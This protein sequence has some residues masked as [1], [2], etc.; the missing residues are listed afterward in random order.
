MLVELGGEIRAEGHDEEGDDDDDEDGGRS[1]LVKEGEFHAV[2]L[3]LRL[4]QLALLSLDLAFLP[5]Y[6]G[7]GNVTPSGWDICPPNREPSRPPGVGRLRRYLLLFVLQEFNSHGQ[8]PRLKNCLR[9]RLRI[10]LRFPIQGGWP[11][12]NGKKI[13]CCQAQLGQATCLAVA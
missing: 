8:K 1:C 11:T 12:G 4:A 5:F 7:R 9:N 13:S 10:S 2:A 6:P 3:H